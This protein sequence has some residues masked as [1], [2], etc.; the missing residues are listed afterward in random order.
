MRST[1]D[2]S[3]ND[4]LSIGYN[5]IEIERM[6]QIETKYNLSEYSLSTIQDIKK[7][8]WKQYL[9]KIVAAEKLKNEVDSLELYIKNYDI[10]EG[11]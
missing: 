7:T 5:S 3:A 11:E 10:L 1:I 4:L 6:K 2:K 8:L 9:D